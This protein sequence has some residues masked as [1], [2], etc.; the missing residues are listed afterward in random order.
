MRISEKTIRRSGR[1]LRVVELVPVRVEKTVRMMCGASGLLFIVLAIGLALF[2]PQ[3]ADHYQ[4][5]VII[6]GVVIG[7]SLILAAIG[8]LVYQSVDRASVRSGIR[9][10]GV[11]HWSPG[12]PTTKNQVFEIGR[13]DDA[14]LFVTVRRLEGEELLS[15]GP[16]VSGDQAVKA[17]TLL[18]PA[19]R[20]EDV[21]EVGALQIIQ[22]LEGGPPLI[23]LRTMMLAMFA[24]LLLPAWFDRTWV[25]AG[26]SVLVGL[27][28]L[29]LAVVWVA[30]R[31]GVFY[32]T[33]DS[34]SV[35]FWTRHKFLRRLEYRKSLA[36]NDPPVFIRRKFHWATV[37]WLL[38]IPLYSAVVVVLVLR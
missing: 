19:Q 23:V 4:L 14:E 2:V 5:K 8:R 6:L 21:G 31:G 28:L 22:Q 26:L 29:L 13:N 34:E 33:D 16:F 10:L 1:T 15:I 27:P 30:P 24:I 17:S 32:Q 12:I 35:E 38:L 3:F 9:W 37:G 18:S 11:T 25:D 20:D 36:T 7:G